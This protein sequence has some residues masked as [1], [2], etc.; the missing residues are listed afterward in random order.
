MIVSLDRCP[1]WNK[2]HIGSQLPDCVGGPPRGLILR[3]SP[4]FLCR[5][6]DQVGFLKVSDTLMSAGETNG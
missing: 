6:R 1:G 5:N 2:K 3:Q 4:C